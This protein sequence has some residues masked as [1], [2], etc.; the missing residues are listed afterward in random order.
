MRRDGM[1]DSLIEQF[2]LETR[3]HL[4]EASRG[5]LAL[6]QSQDDGP[7]FNA[8]FRNFQAIQGTS[9]IFETLAPISS[10][11]HSAENLMDSV[12]KNEITLTPEMTDLLLNALD[13]VGVWM[14]SIRETGGLPADAEKRSDQ[15]QSRLV[16][17]AAGAGEI[18]GRTSP[19]T[20]E[21]PE[22]ASGGRDGVRGFLENFSEADRQEIHDNARGVDALVGIHFYPDADSF[23]LGV[24]PLAFLKQVPTLLKLIVAGRERRPD[25]ETFD[26]FV[27][28]LDFYMIAGDSMECLDAIFGL[29]EDRVTVHVFSPDA[30]AFP[31]GNPWSPPAEI[32]PGKRLIRAYED[33]DVDAVKNILEEVMAELIIAK[34]HLDRP[35]EWALCRRGAPELAEEIDRSRDAIDGVVEKLQNDIAWIQGMDK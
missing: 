28:N 27:C 14:D 11:T 6:G 15:L 5:L 32:V 16:A 30:L 33:S 29:V 17:F 25:L 24:D 31:I 12:R 23:F 22:E 26:P 9:G 35:L 18:P 10:L 2:V 21:A 1:M 34:N 7:L 19:P 8:V 3:D 20:R 4:E 13:Q